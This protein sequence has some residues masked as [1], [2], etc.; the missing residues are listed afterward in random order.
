MLE[1]IKDP[2]NSNS[3]FNTKTQGKP[4]VVILLDMSSSMSPY[5]D[6]VISTFNEYVASVKETAN[7]LSLYMFDTNGIREKI[8]KENPSRIRKLNRD[9][10]TPCGGTPLYDAMGILIKKF[11]SS[12]RNV[13]FVTHTD[14]EENASKE[15]NFIS[16]NAYITAMTA[17]GWLFTYL[18]E[19]IS[20]AKE[21]TKF[22]SGLKVMYSPNNRGLAMKN[23]AM[24]TTTY[25]STC[26]NE[27]QNYTANQ[28]GIVDVDK[29]ESVTESKTS[30]A[31]SK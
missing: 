19:G 15:W 8:L 11:E 23:F 29:N 17:R 4:D 24:S 2:I 22:D 26:S 7:T 9:D 6:T 16:L 25:S 5:R 10:Y 18:G 27:L 13:Q 1:I 30:A 14:G 21:F 20:G 28:F 3:Q 31:D 12:K